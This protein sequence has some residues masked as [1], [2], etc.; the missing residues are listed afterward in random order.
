MTAR[1]W[2]SLAS[3]LFALP[4]LALAGGTTE[5]AKL[6]ASD[7]ELN[8]RFGR[9]ALQGD[10]ALVGCYN[11]DELAVGAGSVYVYT[12]TPSGWVEEPKIFAVGGAA[13]DWFG[14]E[15]ALDGDT[16]LIG[17]SR[18]DTSGTGITG[19]AY[20]FTRTGTAWT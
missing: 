17:A 18:D 13:H 12:R 5:R 1:V 16:A 19:A 4:A 20:V 10:T 6:V 3:T 8:D 9:V 14:R 7:G 2:L 11:D 15:L